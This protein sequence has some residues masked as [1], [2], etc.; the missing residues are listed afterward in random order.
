VGRHQRLQLADQ[1]A[2]AAQAELELDASLQRGQP[3]LFQPGQ[4]R[5][6]GEADGQ[7]AQDRPAPQGQRLGQGLGRGI[8]VAVPVR[9]CPAAASRWNSA[10]SNRWPPGFRR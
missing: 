8:R 4:G 9:S 10:R 5:L 6:R 3:L 1:V 7:V 2:V